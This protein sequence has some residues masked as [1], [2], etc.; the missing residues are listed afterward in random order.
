MSQ[1]ELTTFLGWFTLLNYGA[2]AFSFLMLTILRGPIMA[3][4]SKATGVPEAEL[5]VLYFQFY[6]LYKVIIMIF[7]L[8]PWIILRYIM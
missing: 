5:P 7:G 3:I 6:A 1:G 8:I 4:H 2:I